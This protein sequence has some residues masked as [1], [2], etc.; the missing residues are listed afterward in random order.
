VAGTGISGVLT[1]LI[2]LTLNLIY[3]SSMNDIK[4][5]VILPDKRIF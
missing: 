3:T 4:D 5:A 1:N 2:V